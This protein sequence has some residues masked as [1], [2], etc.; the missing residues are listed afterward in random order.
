MS[1]L[2]N[3]RIVV[4]VADIAHIAGTLNALDNLTCH[5]R[6]DVEIQVQPNFPQGPL[7]PEDQKLLDDRLAE[8]RKVRQQVESIST[9]PPTKKEN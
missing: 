3:V 5:V 9:E 4:P 8:S 6:Y 2:N 7:S 1:R